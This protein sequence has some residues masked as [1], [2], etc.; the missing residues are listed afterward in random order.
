MRVRGKV[1][2]TTV[3]LEGSLPEGADVDVV[4]RNADS[5]EGCEVSEADWA[6]LLAAAAEARAGRVVSAE[7]VLAK[8]RRRQST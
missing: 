8:L 5:E 1:V 7:T 3:V 2:G 4:L 6:D